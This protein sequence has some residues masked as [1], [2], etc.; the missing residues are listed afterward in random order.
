MTRAET[1]TLSPAGPPPRSIRRIGYT[2]ETGTPSPD[3]SPQP[4]Q[5][6]IG[7]GVPA[8]KARRAAE[9]GTCKRWRGTAVS[10][11]VP[12]S[13]WITVHRQRQRRS[14]GR[15]PGVCAETGTLWPRETVEKLVE[16]RTY[17]RRIRFGRAAES[18][19][20]TR[21]FEFGRT[22]NRVRMRAESGT[23]TCPFGFQIKHV[24]AAYTVYK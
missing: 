14:S 16:S 8:P 12:D 15:R 21:R 9:S 3:A 10:I 4:W 23:Y 5:R 17:P 7:Y 13:A 11:F 1:G 22:Q 20:P 19:S 6:R 2:A 18:G 24:Y